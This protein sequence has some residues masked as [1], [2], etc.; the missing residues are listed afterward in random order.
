MEVTI[1]QDLRVLSEEYGDITEDVAREMAAVRMEEF[2]RDMAQAD[3]RQAALWQSTQGE[4]RVAKFG[5]IKAQIDPFVFAHWEQRYG[6]GFFG[7]KGNLEWFLKKCP[8][9]R[10]KARSDRLTVQGVSMPGRT[11]VRGRRGRWAL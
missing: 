4:G 7:E 8:A 2:D 3:A 9:A 5:A 10:V 1:T 6:H 11:G